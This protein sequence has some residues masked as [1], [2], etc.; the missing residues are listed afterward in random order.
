MMVG[1]TAVTTRMAPKTLM[2]QV[3]NDWT[4]Y[5]TEVSTDSVSLVN[6][7]HTTFSP[8]AH[9]KQLK[10]EVG[11]WSATTLSVTAHK[12]SEVSARVLPYSCVTAVTYSAYI[13]CKTQRLLSPF[14]LCTVQRYY[15]T[16]C[17]GAKHTC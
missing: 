12:L 7:H 9:S 11:F 14:A 13:G 4:E 16:P 3:M 15:S 8:Y 6:L 1:V 5:D 17:P 2:L 10:L